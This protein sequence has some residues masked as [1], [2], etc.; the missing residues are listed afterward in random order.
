MAAAHGGCGYGTACAC[1]VGRYRVPQRAHVYFIRI[2]LCKV[3]L[4]EACAATYHSNCSERLRIQN[5]HKIENCKETAMR[6]VVLRW[7]PFLVASDALITVYVCMY[8]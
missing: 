1:C 5:E 7:M 8:V 4:L 6:D 3:L 2:P